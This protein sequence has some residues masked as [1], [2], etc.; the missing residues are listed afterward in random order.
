MT[1]YFRLRKNTANAGQ[2]ASSF[3]CSWLTYAV[4]VIQQNNDFHQEPCKPNQ[5]EVRAT[6]NHNCAIKCRKCTVV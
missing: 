6:T 3:L 5:A 1:V 2:N 4:L